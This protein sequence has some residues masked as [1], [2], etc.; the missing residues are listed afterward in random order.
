MEKQPKN[1]ENI[2]DRFM[3]FIGNP[4]NGALGYLDALQNENLSNESKEKIINNL[5]A[6]WNDIFNRIETFR[7]SD[8][9]PAGKI[10]IENLDRILAYKNKNPLNPKIIEE[11]NNLYNSIVDQ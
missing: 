8:F 3:D 9:K 10:T 6:S 4:L 11:L 1:I 2:R 7:N 5:T